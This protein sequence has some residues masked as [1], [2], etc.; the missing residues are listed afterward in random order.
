[1]FALYF[2]EQA[3]NLTAQQ[4]KA[5]SPS[6]EPEMLAPE[7]SGSNCEETALVITLIS[8]RRD[9]AEKLQ[10]EC[11]QIFLDGKNFCPLPSA[12]ES[13]H[14][15]PSYCLSMTPDR[16]A[17]SSRLTGTEDPASRPMECSPRSPSFSPH[18][19]SAIM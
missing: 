11:V 14:R 8:F 3:N 9:P 18:N 19:Y 6:A 12:P 13:H 16:V 15:T 17:K 10:P 4:N 2:P 7:Q 5:R 1:M